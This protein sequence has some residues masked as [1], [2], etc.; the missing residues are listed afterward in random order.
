VRRDLQELSDAGLLRRVH[1]GALPPSPPGPDSFL[2]R[3]PD[4]VAAKAAVAKAA[5]GLV[6]PGEVIAISGGTTTLEFAR[7]LPD[8]LDATVIATNPH[9]AMALA[10]H[11]GTSRWMSSAVGCWAP[12]GRSWAPM[13]STP[14]ERC[15]RTSACSLPAH[16][17]RASA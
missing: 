2:E 13:P 15:V 7:R 12:R 4:D 11:P 6:R 14:C 1:G 10:D 3:L 17:I 16:C 9:I 8:D 5:V